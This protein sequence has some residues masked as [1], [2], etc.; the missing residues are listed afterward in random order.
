[1]SDDLDSL[2]HDLGE[3]PRHAGRFVESAL[4]KTAH[5][6]KEDWVDLAKGP[7]GAHAK[8]YPASIDYDITRS[9]FPHFEAEVGPN[10]GAAQGP[11]GI[12]EE[13]NGDVKSPPQNLRS[14]VVRANES[15]FVRG[16]E[17]AREDALRRAGL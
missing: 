6:M 1:M 14:N 16:M 15:D 10:L 3:F 17:Q 5:G 12:L 8:R 11:L 9:D 4:K 7:S 2:I 13:A